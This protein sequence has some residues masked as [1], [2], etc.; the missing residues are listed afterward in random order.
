M[1]EAVAGVDPIGALDGG[2][3]YADYVDDDDDVC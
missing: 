3:A 1:G 2:A